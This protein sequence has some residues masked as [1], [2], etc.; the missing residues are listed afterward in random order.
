MPAD[1][2]PD[3]LLVARPWFRKVLTAGA[4]GGK[5]AG[6]TCKADGNL[7]TRPA[8]ALSY[9]SCPLTLSSDSTDLQS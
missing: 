6:R 1:Q 8:P 4:V 7:G 3:D 5:L 9:V 2:E